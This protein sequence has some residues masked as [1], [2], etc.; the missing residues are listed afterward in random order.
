MEK[1]ARIV[2][3]NYVDQNHCI[4]LGGAQNY[5]KCLSEVLYSLGFL[6]IV[7]QTAQKGFSV[8]FDN[9]RVI[10]V[11]G[12][13]NS[14]GIMRFIDKHEHDYDNDLLVFGTD[15]LICRNNFKNC[16]AVQHGVAWD[17]TRD[18][19]VSGFRNCLAILK[20]S[21]RSFKKYSRYRYCKNLVCVDYNFLNWY[22][23]Q[24]LHIDNNCFVIPNF[25]AG[26]ERKREKRGTGV[27]IVFARRLVDYRGTK[28]FTEAIIPLLE[29]Y[30]ELYV[31][32]AGTGPDEDWM[33]ERLS[34]FSNV[35]FTSFSA[36]D[37]V[38]FHSDYDIAVV[39]TKGSE[40]TSLSLLEA[41]SA[42]CAAITTNVGGL[43][44][45]ILDGY[46]GLIIDPEVMELREAMEKLILDPEKR[47]RLSERA[48]ETV[49][50][51]FSYEKW[52]NSWKRV[53]QQIIGE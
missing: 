39:P 33:K 23:T 8:E 9:C 49:R 26:Y 17:I 1:H 21:L 12:A 29:N 47:E 24:V 53:I 20:G 35:T 50:E 31:T 16:I 18:E 40:G 5:V 15:F 28:L 48:V 42:G 22:R 44:N 41:M 7:Y 27:S 38:R 34:R 13:K 14:Q 4:T 43:T 6:P 2:F 36:Q 25:A 30:S 52:V 11:E 51:C 45:I 3:N 19:S 46:N 10:G 37:S 32:V